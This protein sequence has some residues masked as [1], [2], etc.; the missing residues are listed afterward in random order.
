L[1]DVP[2]RVVVDPNGKIVAIGIEEATAIRRA[3]FLC[4]PLDIYRDDRRWPGMINAGYRC[5]PGVVQAN[6]TE[7]KG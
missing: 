5:V 6:P 4:G 2:L 1:K 3:V 7:R